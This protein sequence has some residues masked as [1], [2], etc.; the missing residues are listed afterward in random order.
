MEFNLISPSPCQSAGPDRTK[1]ESE[2]GSAAPQQPAQSHGGQDPALL[3]Y[4]DKKQC[5]IKELALHLLCC[6][7]LEKYS[8][9]S[10]AAL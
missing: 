5:K 2:S 1:P 6:P 10:L 3:L 4:S 8:S 9:D 7:F